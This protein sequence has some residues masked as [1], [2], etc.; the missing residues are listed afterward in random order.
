VQDVTRPFK[1]LYAKSS[2]F[3]L[4]VYHSVH[5]LEKLIREKRK[6]LKEG[7]TKRITTMTLRPR[8]SFKIF[9]EPRT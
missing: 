8:R 9:D 1:K 7:F 2:D 3:D 5:Y 6:K 4:E